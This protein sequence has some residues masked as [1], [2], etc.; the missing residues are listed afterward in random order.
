MVFSEI[1]YE[2]GWQAYLDGQPVEHIRANYI[3]RAMQV[4]AGKHTIEFRFAPKSYEIGNTVSM[5]SSIV[6]LLVIAGA[7]FYGVK[8]KPTE[9]P[10]AVK[11]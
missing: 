9:E 7:V 6:L 2:A 8:K 4:P 10:A 3:L 1:Y 11:V 5:I